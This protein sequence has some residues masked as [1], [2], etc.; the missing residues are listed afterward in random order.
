MRGRH[1]RC[2]ISASLDNK[3]QSD[4]MKQTEPRSLIVTRVRDQGPDT[5]SFDLLP[6][7]AEQSHGVTFIPGQVA[8]LGVPDEEPAYFAFASAPEDRELEILVKRAAGASVKIFNMKEG[9][10]LDLL[11]VTG[12]G[13]DLDRHR[14]RDLVLVAM[15]TG[16]APLRSALRHVLR[17]KDEFGKLVVLYG[18]RT[19]DDFCYRD[20]TEGWEDAGVELRQVISRPGDRNWSGPTGYVQSLLDHVL[21]DLKLPVALVC[22]SREMIAQTRDRLQ[23]M[24]FPADAILT[25]Y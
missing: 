22:G 12:H 16:V 15:G 21:P 17:Q 11:A 18:A 25:N 5:R 23:Q 2:L 6:V 13:F 1:Y 10:R 24:G 19:P 20:E 7:G 8:M 9:E 14:G 3:L 4:W